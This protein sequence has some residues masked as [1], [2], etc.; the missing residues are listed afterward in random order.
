MV[1][2]RSVHL[3][4]TSPPYN[5]EKDYEK[6]QTLDEWKRLL[7]D[8]FSE[9]YRVLV[10]GGR[11]AINVA[12]TWRN[13]Y[14]PLH[15]YIMEILDE[16]DFGMRGEIIW[17]KNASVGASTAWGSWNSA[18]NPSLRDVHEYILVYS[19]G[20]WGRGKGKSTIVKDEF[21]SYTKSIWSFPTASAKKVGHP[22]PFP[23]ELPTRLI[24]LYSFEGDTVLDPFAGSGTTCIASMLE[25]RRF[26]GFDNNPDYVKTAVK[27]LEG[28]AT[29][30]ALEMFK[31]AEQFVKENHPND[32]PW[33]K[34]ILEK[35][36]TNHNHLFS[37]YA[38]IVYLSG[39]RETVVSAKW[40]ALS[41]AY[42]G[43]DVDYVIENKEK[44]RG[45]AFPIFKNEKKLDAILRGVAII[46]KIPD[47]KKFKTEAEED[48]D[49][50]KRLPYIADVLKFHLAKNIGLDVCKPDVHLVRLSTNAGIKPTSLMRDPE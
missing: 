8:V 32:I 29:S 1:P 22:A 40:E 28:Y 41:K 6:D 19:K 20:P 25:G 21:L 27:R 23:L 44:V 46:K 24:K 3:V 45:E 50:L 35:G 2:S 37:E 31:T 12:G 34:E 43:F 13:P 5:V 47:L 4:I 9:C 36:I 16:F 30:I 17:D 15:R 10:P 7:R 33:S 18:S 48:I 38:Y 42:G 26:W 14:L 49:S 39:F 11:I